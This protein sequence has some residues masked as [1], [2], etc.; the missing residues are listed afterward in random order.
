MRGF[1]HFIDTKEDNE[2]IELYN[3]VMHS[4]REGR[5]DTGSKEKL[6]LSIE[7]ASGT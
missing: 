2:L 1:S 4:V 7:V 3:L 6:D 5:K